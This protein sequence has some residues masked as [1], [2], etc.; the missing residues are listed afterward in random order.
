MADEH[1]L[2]ETRGDCESAGIHDFFTD[3]SDR[4]ALQSSFA[5]VARS[6]GETTLQP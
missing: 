2:R 3:R 1:E 4:R 6:L 5:I